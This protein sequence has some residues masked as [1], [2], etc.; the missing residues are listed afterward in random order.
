M[1]ILVPP[2]PYYGSKSRVAQQIVAAMPEHRRYVEPFAGGLSVL[3]AK[4]RARHEVFNDLDGDLMCFWRILRD[5]PEALARACS[6]TP[7]SREERTLALDLDGELPDLEWARRVW[8]ALV[9]GRHGTLQGTGWRWDKRSDAHPMPQRMAA[10]VERMD[11]VATRLRGVTLESRD[12]LDV[13]S[14]YGHD[15]STLLY[16]DPPYLARTRASNYRCEMGSVAAHRELAT[17]LVGCRATVVL[18]G[19]ADGLYAE[20]YPGWHRMEIAA[21]TTQGGSDPGRV[22]VLWG[23]REFRYID[24][25]VGHKCNEI[26]RCS[27]C[28]RVLPVATGR[29]RRAV[30]CGAACRVAAHRQRQALTASAGT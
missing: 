16:V 12:A 14:D 4:P 10:M 5:Q 2:I 25:D 15:P 11:A 29:G 26:N 17:A 22:E 13:I 19:Y 9:Q 8:S 3:L 6:L 24:G 18:S 1:T 7:H 20:M 23:N 28:D 30:Y 21:S 27:H